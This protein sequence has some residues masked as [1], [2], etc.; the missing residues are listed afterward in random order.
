[1]GGEG[2]SE[3]E[4]PFLDSGGVVTSGELAVESGDSSMVLSKVG[5]SRTDMSVEMVDR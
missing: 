2:G 5:D 1:M 4:R 3:T